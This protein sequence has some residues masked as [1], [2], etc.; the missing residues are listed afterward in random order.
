LKIEIEEQIL[1]LD[2]YRNENFI[3]VFL[4]EN[5]QLFLFQYFVDKLEQNKVWFEIIELQWK[6]RDRI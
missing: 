4:F 2:L 5:F 3:P 1:V 6:I